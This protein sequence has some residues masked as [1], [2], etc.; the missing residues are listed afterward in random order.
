MCSA[1]NNRSLERNEVS[2]P[3]RLFLEVSKGQTEGDVERK[4]LILQGGTQV[5]QGAT[6]CSCNSTPFFFFFFFIE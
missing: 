6:G 2:T 3:R 1:L 4:T 5:L